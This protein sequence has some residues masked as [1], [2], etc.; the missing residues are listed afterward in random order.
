MVRP[1]LGVLFT[2]SERFHASMYPLV[3]PRLTNQLLRRM[4]AR[5]ETF[6]VTKSES[7]ADSCEVFDITTGEIWW[8]DTEDYDKLSNNGEILL[9]ERSLPELVGIYLRYINASNGYTATS[10]FNQ[11]RQEAAQLLLN[12]YS[13]MQQI[14]DN[15]WLRGE[16]VSE[17]K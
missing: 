3:K 17:E 15:R 6:L 2:V 7:R 8:M 12:F 5:G 16:D 1:H 14:K 10:Q 9:T 13:T 4:L 11:G